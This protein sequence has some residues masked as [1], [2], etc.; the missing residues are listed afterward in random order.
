MLGVTTPQEALKLALEK[1][2]DLVEIS[3]SASPPVCKIMNYGKFKYEI[4]KKSQAAKKKQKVVET[5]E[6]KIRPTIAEGDYKVK[7]KNALRFLDDG[8]KVRISLQFKGREITHDEVG[9]ALISRFEKDLTDVAK[10]EAAP[11]LEG[12]QIFM[13]L[14]PK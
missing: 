11:K 8:N 14:S 6:I 1:S 4:Q 2:L 7:L 3:P 12:K 5:K 10:I 9:F 13:I